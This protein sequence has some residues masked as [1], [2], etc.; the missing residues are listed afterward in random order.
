M[1][2][3]GQ[4]RSQHI[5]P[6]IPSGVNL[7]TSIGAA[8]PSANNDKIPDKAQANMSSCSLHHA[9]IVSEL[10]FYSSHLLIRTSLLQKVS[11]NF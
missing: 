11:I 2:A 6:E 8:L 7:H 9:N 4:D 5:G 3:L 1:K 10:S